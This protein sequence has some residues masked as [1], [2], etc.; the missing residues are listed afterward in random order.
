[1]RLHLGAGNKRFEGFVNI[2]YDKKSNPDYC[3]DIE[4]EPWPFDYDSVDQVIA[5]HVFE[6]LGEGYFHV[7]KELYRVC[8]HGAMIDIV[9]P[10]HRH[11]YFANDPT[12]RRAITADGLWL[13][14]KKY[15]DSCIEQDAAASRLGHY[16][17]VDFEVVDSQNIP[18]PKYIPMFTGKTIEEVERYMHEH[19]NTIMEVHIKLVVIK[20]YV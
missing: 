4:K 16:F 5:H 3:F 17:G 20:E 11:E 18:D 1:M 13:F 8:M 7:L 6:H 10:H 19:N 12:H 15:N 2:D 14:S 9:V